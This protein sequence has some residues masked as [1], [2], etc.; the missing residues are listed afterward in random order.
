MIVVYLLTGRAT[1][2]QLAWESNYAYPSTRVKDRGPMFVG[3]PYSIGGDMVGQGG[4]N[5]VLPLQFLVEPVNQSNAW[6]LY[7]ELAA[8][9]QKSGDSLD[10]LRTLRSRLGDGSAVDSSRDDLWSLMFFLFV[11]RIEPEQ[12]L[13]GEKTLGE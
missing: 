12:Y 1:T 8:L 4:L 2:G 5:V 7:R 13:S 3:V 11:S 6:A 10:F 9:A